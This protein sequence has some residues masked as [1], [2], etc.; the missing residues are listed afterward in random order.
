MNLMLLILH[1]Y[2]L[3]GVINLALT[4]LRYT[5]LVKYMVILRETL[6]DVY[7]MLHEFHYVGVLPTRLIGGNVE[8]E[9]LNF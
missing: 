6:Y 8:N 3:Q 9:V 2:P 1:N 5:Y 4:P 7:S